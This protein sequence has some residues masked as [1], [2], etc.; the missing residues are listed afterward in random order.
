M[1]RPLQQGASGEYQVVGQNLRTLLYYVVCAAV[2]PLHV[3][4]LL[5]CAPAPFR[6]RY[7]IACHWIAIQHFVLRHVVGLNYQIEGLD[8]IPAGG[9]VLYCKH[10]SMVE[11]ITTQMFLPPQTWVIKRELLWVPVFG[12]GLALLNPIAID[13]RA[14]RSAVEQIVSQGRALFKRGIWVVIF[15]EGTRM[16]PGETRRYG[17]GGAVLASE[18]GVPVVPLAHNAGRFWL[19]G[20]L[21]IQ[22]GTFRVR[23]GPPIATEGLTPEEINAKARAWMDQAMAEIDTPEV[24]VARPVVAR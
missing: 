21:V 20:R 11:C 10:Q 1:N 2:M 24:E 15:P 19:K 18:T 23:I 4:A 12:W 22:P 6:Y 8:N 3:V 17:L 13:R 16:P 14:G 7:A 9:A 5:L